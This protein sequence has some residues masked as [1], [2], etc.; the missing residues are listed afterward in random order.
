M[1]AQPTRRDLLSAVAVP[2]AG[3]LPADAAT[4]RSAPW[5]AELAERLALATRA[6][7]TVRN[8]L[9]SG[10][11]ALQRWEGRNPFPHAQGVVARYEWAQR[12]CAAFEAAGM[13]QRRADNV[14]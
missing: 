8:R 10:R 6:R 12:Y 2:L 11:D 9:H 7:N 13:S 5:G 4:D 1:N 14:A 3:S